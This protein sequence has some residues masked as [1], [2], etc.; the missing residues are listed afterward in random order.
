MLVN[1]GSD[2]ARGSVTVAVTWRK[3]RQATVSDSFDFFSYPHREFVLWIG[4]YEEPK[5]ERS[6]V[7]H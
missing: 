7:T 6:G 2:K 4:G 3:A 5:I 1:V